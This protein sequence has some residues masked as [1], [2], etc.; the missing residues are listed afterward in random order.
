MVFTAD[1]QTL[2]GDLVADSISTLDVTLQNGSALTGSINPDNTAQ[3][4]NL[5]LDATSTWTV[6]ADSHLTCLDN[7]DGIIAGEVTNIIGNGF[8]VTY[9]SDVC[10]A[11]DGQ[12]VT[13]TG[14]GSLQPA[15]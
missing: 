9:D 10:T 4:A 11:L 2:A 7:P 12:T 6:T 15:N 1:A 13:L 5:T 3:V 8:T 14:G